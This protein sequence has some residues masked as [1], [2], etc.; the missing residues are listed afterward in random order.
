MGTQ[1]AENP[2]PVRLGSVNVG[3]SIVIPYAIGCLVEREHC[4]ANS[5]IFRFSSR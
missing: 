3:Y 5:A 4:K 1:R 2:R